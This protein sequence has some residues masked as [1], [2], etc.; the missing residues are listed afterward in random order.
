[1]TND[2]YARIYF[3]ARHIP[4]GKVTT[5][6]QLG[7]MC[8][9]SDSRTVGDA[10]H[11]APEDVPWQRVLNARGTISLQG[12]PGARQRARLESEGVAFDENGRIDFAKAGWLPDAAW[13]TA[14]GYLVPPRLFPERPDT[15]IEQLNLF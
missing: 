12:A 4:Y 14:H 6:G 8:E 5:Y 3:L 7:A 10:M 9:V 11:A 2:L 13:L 1:M 15:D